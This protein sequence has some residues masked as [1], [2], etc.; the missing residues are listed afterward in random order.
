M[1]SFLVRYRV[2]NKT[3]E[4]EVFSSDKKEASET[5]K[6]QAGWDFPDKKVKIISLKTLKGKTRRA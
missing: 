6:I 1:E 4:E 5:I 2:G 3:F